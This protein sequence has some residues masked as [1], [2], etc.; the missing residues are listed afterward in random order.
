SDSAI[1]IAKV[2]KSAVYAKLTFNVGNDTPLRDKRVRQVISGLLDTEQLIKT[3]LHGEAVG[4]VGPML[5]IFQDRVPTDFK[6]Y[7]YTVEEAR[8]LLDEAGY[9]EFS[10]VMGCNQGDATHSKYTQ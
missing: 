3:V 7:S 9:G 10:L 4:F 6:P 1:E 5:P 8:K 2:E